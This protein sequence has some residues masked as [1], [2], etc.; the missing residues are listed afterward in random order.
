MIVFGSVDAQKQLERDKRVA[1][2]DD[3]ERFLMAAITTNGLIDDDPA[4]FARAV[5]M[6]VS[7]WWGV[8]ELSQFLNEIYNQLIECGALLP[9]RH[10]NDRGILGAIAELIEKW[11]D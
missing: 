6:A 11:N 10:L 5:A 4:E 3:V 2:M 8:W 7:T 9:D 1:A